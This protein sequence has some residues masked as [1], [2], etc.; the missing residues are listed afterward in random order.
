MK[1]NKISQHYKKIYRLI[2]CGGLILLLASL[3]TNSIIVINNGIQAF[4]KEEI[5]FLILKFSINILASIAFIEIIIKPERCEFFAL[6][7]LIYTFDIL[8]ANAANL[9][10]VFMAILAIVVLTMRGFFVKKKTLKIIILSSLYILA[11]CTEIRFGRV[12][13][14]GSVLNNIA[15]FF[16]SAIIFLFIQK[17]LASIT[18]RYEP[19][20]LDLT[21]YK[22]LT[23]LDKEII[24]LLKEGQKYEWIAGNQGIATSTLKKHVKRIFEILDV[25]DLVEFHAEFGGREVIYTKEE[26]H[27]WKK[28]FLEENHPG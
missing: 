1:T 12:A 15:A 18:S 6:I 14:I 16:I 19:R 5:F 22:D 17:Y 27:E 25:A 21:K 7:S 24:K 10:S 4:N 23:A 11:L 2:G 8:I 26:L 9:I 13:F 28:R 3:I 20:I